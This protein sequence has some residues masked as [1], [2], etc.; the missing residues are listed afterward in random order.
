MEFLLRLSRCR[1]PKLA[2]PDAVAGQ[3]LNTDSGC[4]WSAPPPAVVRLVPSRAHQ[5]VASVFRSAIMAAGNLGADGMSRMKD[6]ALGLVLAAMGVAA[7][8]QVFPVDPVWRFASIGA[9]S[10][11][12]VLAAAVFFVFAF[13]PRND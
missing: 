4:L 3:D 9:L 13:S 1:S 10:A 11:I 5:P 7:F 2:V 6:F 8:V 12:S